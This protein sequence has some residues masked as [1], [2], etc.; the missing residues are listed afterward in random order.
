MKQMEFKIPHKLTLF[1][2]NQ[3]ILSSNPAIA[4]IPL[5]NSSN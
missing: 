3:D 5:P 1:E 2:S 4:K